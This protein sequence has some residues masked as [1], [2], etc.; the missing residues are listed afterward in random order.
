ML[1]GWR[2]NLAVIVGG[3]GGIVGLYFHYKDPHHPLALDPN[4]AMPL[5]VAAL[6]LLGIGGKLDRV[7]EEMKKQ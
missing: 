7:N 3:I 1:N 6:G 4:V 2:T 5:I